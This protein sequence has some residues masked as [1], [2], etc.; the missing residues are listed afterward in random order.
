MNA[1]NENA[2]RSREKHL[3]RDARLLVHDLF[4]V[5]PAIYW[6]DY[7]LSATVAY[8]AAAMFA[9]SAWN[10][11]LT[12]LC[13][14][15]AVAMLY[16]ISMFVHEAIHFRR[17]QMN[18]F[19]LFWDLTAGI[20]MLMPTS[21]YESHLSHHNTAAYGTIKD[22]EYLP[23]AGGGLPG[24]L[25]FL[26]QILFQPVLVFLRYL[27]G[28]PVSF[29]H[30]AWREWL[31]QHASSLVINFRYHHEHQQ[32]KL[33]AGQVAI[34]WGCCLRAACLILVVV[35][36]FDSPDRLLKIYL[37]ATAALTLNHIRTL[38]AH[39]YQSNGEPMSH[40]DQFL[41]S[42]NITGTWLTEIICPVGLRYHALH[43]LFP[44][45]PYYN[46]GTAHRRL[47]SQLPSCSIYFQNIYPTVIAAL[48]DFSRSLRRRKS[49]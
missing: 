5:Q 21:S 20:P 35:A 9:N 17:G 33:T 4:G 34:E 30:P 13:F 41:D 40:A 44:S 36:G 29:L 18:G 27:V 26:L 3:I 7:T 12:W 49:R 43:H 23:L 6:L 19:R 46:L 24:V 28:T 31:N 47:V 42:T 1:L 2:L 25:A 38:A 32:P 8:V 22:A 37:L 16:R 10:S 48:M 45:I 39:R 14:P 11:W 15:I